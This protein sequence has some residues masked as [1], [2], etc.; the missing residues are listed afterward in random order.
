MVL[1]FDGKGGRGW[2]LRTGEEEETIPLSGLKPQYLDAQNQ[3]N[4][5]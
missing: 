1:V 5:A 3:T 2:G 4:I